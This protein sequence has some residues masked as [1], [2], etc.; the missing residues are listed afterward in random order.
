MEWCPIAN[1]DNTIQLR[2]VPLDMIAELLTRTKLIQYAKEQ[3]FFSDDPKN[4]KTYS[5]HYI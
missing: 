2:G 1:F 5:K 3:G 4:T